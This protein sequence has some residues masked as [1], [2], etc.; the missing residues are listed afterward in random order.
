MLRASQNRGRRF[1]SAGGA[2]E[3]PAP[4][5]GSVRSKA[6]A[7]LSRRA[8]TRQAL[9]ERLQQ[10]GY[11]DEARADAIAYLAD[12]GYLDDRAFALQ[13]LESTRARR[14]H[15]RGWLEK[16]L[17]GKGVPKEIIQE[18]LREHCDREGELERALD[19]A[20]SLLSRSGTL[21][22]ERLASR[23]AS[24]GFS[25]ELIR[26]TLDVLGPELRARLEES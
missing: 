1:G 26:Q 25:W 5:P 9:A 10:E 8:W 12:C 3:A 15:G 16:E 23:L 17:R 21:S 14:G 6:L 19:T 18:V 24:R 2:R 11:D 20:R 13:F 22:A 4:A 7:L